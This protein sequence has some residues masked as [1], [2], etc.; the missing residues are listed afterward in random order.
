MQTSAA[1]LR[2]GQ[3]VPSICKICRSLLL[4]LK[5]R[6]SNGTNC[7]EHSLKKNTV[8]KSRVCRSQWPSVGLR[9]VAY[10]DHGFESRWGHGWLSVVSVVCVLRYRSLRW[11]DHSSRGVLP[12]VVCP[13]VWSCNLRNEEAQIRKG[14]KMPDRRSQESSLFLF[15]PNV[16]EQVYTS[17]PPGSIF[18][19]RKASLPHNFIKHRTKLLFLILFCHLPPRPS[20]LRSIVSVSDENS[21]LLLMDRGTFN[22]V[23]ILRISE[24]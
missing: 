13:C 24:S 16:C 20:Q 6:T 14:C 12:T 3:T 15:N 18:N 5:I 10:W 2:N 22:A 11:A 1:V 17:Q 21:V 7:T 23:K 8:T 19:R 4:Q 9:T